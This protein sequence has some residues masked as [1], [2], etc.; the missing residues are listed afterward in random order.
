MHLRL[1][2]KSGYTTADQY[3]ASSDAARAL[4]LSVAI[5]Q[6][7]WTEAVNQ[8]KELNKLRTYSLVAKYK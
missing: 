5:T 3:R 1:P 2:K 4:L 7:N 6:R 8:Y